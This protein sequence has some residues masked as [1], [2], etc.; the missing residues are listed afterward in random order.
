ME[1][2]PPEAPSRYPQDTLRDVVL[3]ASWALVAFFHD[4]YAALLIQFLKACARR[5]GP[6]LRFFEMK[7]LTFCA[8][9][10]SLGATI[11]CAAQS[12]LTS[13]NVLPATFKPSQTFKNANLVHIINLEKAYPKETVNLVIENIASTPQ[14]EY[15]IPFTAKQTEQLAGLEVKD[16]KKPELGALKVEPVLIDA[17]RYS[18]CSQQCSSTYSRQRHPLLQDPPP[19]AAAA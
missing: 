10:I 4:I 7:S 18:P 9:V 17:E 5:C 3:N 16:K 8:A 2:R 11:V 6:I 19:E 14:D 13:Q 15:F 12:S 1:P